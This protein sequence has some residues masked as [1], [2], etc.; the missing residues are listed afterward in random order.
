MALLSI[1]VS[2]AL[3]CV[4]VYRFA[5]IGAL[6]PR[7]VSWL[8]IG[9][10]GIA[11]GIGLASCLFF[12]LLPLGV[13]RL[14]FAIRGILLIAVAYDCWRTRRPASKPDAAP[15]HSYMPLLWVALALALVI[16]TYG[17]STAWEANPQGN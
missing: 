13:P 5:G 15:R 11:A 9:G 8:L 6:Q 17:M 10:A 14:S 12:I 4:L 2:I 3:G 16:A 1:L 7:W